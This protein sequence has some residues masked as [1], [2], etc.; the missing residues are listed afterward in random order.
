MLV[1]N[2]S[3]YVDRFVTETD[4]NASIK[5][6]S[7]IVLNVFSRSTALEA[8]SKVYIDVWNTYVLIILIPTKY[9]IT[10]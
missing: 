4:N 9:I 10:F 6:L 1:D 3:S 5:D 8:A 2:L 7:E